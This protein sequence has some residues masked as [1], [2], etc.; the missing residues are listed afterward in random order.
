VRTH[1][2]LFLALLA[3]QT[4]AQRAAIEGRV[5][6]A[7]NG[8]PIPDALVTAVAIS[9]SAPATAPFRPQSAAEYNEVMRAR[10]SGALLPDIGLPPGALGG[11]PPQ[12]SAITDNDGRFRITGVAPGAYTVRSQRDGYFAPPLNGRIQASALASVSV[13]PGQ[14]AASAELRMVKGGVISGRIRDPRGQLIPGMAVAA[15]R[16]TYSNG[17]KVWTQTAPASTDDRGE[18]RLFWLLPGEYFV[19]ATPRPPGT[20]PGPQDLWQRVFYP[21]A[22]D[23]LAAVPVLVR[24]GAEASGIDIQLREFNSPLF[25]ISGLAINPS[26]QANPSTGVVDRSVMSFMLVPRNHNMLD[27]ET[28]A[29]YTNALPVASRL[30]GEFELRN[31]RPGVYDLYPRGPGF[32]VPAPLS[33]VTVN[34]PGGGASIVD[35]SGRIVATNV[36]P[37]SNRRVPMSRI[38]VDVNRDL[39]D[40]RMVLSEGS[41]LAGDVVVSSGASIKLDSVRLSLLP[42]D[43]TP[44]LFVNPIGPISLAA[45]GRFS[46]PNVPDARYTFQIAGLTENAYVS[47]IRQGGASVLDAG[48]IVDPLASPVQVLVNSSGA[49]LDGYVQTAD[50]KPAINATVTLV[51][52][53]SRRETAHRYKVAVTD[54]FGR[55]SMR[56]VAPGSYKLFAWENILP[57]AWQ[58][59]EFLSKYEEQGRPISVPSSGDVQLN[60]IPREDR[61]W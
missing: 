19:G 12:L 10:A 30:N 57:T 8:A 35:A 31:V 1:L 14:S 23:P 28:P 50:R 7:G 44:P 43:T 5:V 18:F 25:K 4:P 22:T 45:N 33:F 49:T 11:A 52:P 29:N 54:E 61:N 34:M 39:A 9:G 46:I 32:A 41:T 37:V 36:P 3:F 51:P 56:G 40:L 6:R 42:L 26:A 17:R 38:A 59:T 48:F 47:D 21:A 27:S 55:F 53:V 20:A 16:V 60:L 58:N 15:Y 13:Q 24:D 2:A